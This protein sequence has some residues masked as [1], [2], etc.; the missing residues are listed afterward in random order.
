MSDQQKVQITPVLALQLVNEG[1]GKLTNLTMK[2]CR[3][4][5]IAL[6]ELARVVAEHHAFT[7]AVKNKRVTEPE[8]DPSQKAPESNGAK[9][10]S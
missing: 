8:T 6:N 1:L 9:H 7:E 2:E 4:L 10:S 3:T 5:D